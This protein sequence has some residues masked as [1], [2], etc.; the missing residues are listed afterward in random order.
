MGL[1]PFLFSE[2][3]ITGDSASLRQRTFHGGSGVGCGITPSRRSLFYG[4]KEGRVLSG[5]L[6]LRHAPP[7]LS[8]PQPSFAWPARLDARRMI[9]HV[10]PN[11]QLGRPLC[12]T[13]SSA[14]PRNKPRQPGPSL[15]TPAHLHRPISSSRLLTC[16]QHSAYSYHIIVTENPQ[17]VVFPSL[18]QLSFQYFSRVARQTFSSR[19]SHG[20]WPIQG[21]HQAVLAPAKQM[22]PQ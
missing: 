17:T 14:Q 5:P 19:G 15:L 6:A 10:A 11:T 18:P 13:N 22:I 3:G 2:R 20:I 9:L 1:Y 21:V 8:T 16:G 4:E 12:P 7:A